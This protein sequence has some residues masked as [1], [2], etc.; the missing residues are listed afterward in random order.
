MLCIQKAMKFI[1]SSLTCNPCNQMQNS[2]DVDNPEIVSN[3]VGHQF[4]TIVWNNDC[5]IV[6]HKCCNGTNCLLE[7]HPLILNWFEKEMNDSQSP[8]FEAAAIKIYSEYKRN[9]IHFR[10]H[11]NYRKTG[12][13]HDWVM[14]MYE[15]DDNSDSEDDDTEN[16]F[17]RNENPSKILCFFM[18]DDSEKSMLWYNLVTLVIINKIPFFFNYGKKEYVRRGNIFQPMLC[19]VPVDS[20]GCSIL[21][22]EDNRSISETSTIKQLQDG[23]TVVI[24]CEEWPKKFLPRIPQHE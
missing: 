3:L 16:L 2:V 17:D 8:F 24:L 9:Q 14:V 23:I 18:V 10:A 7:L 13:W 21:V 5:H 20:F 1:E 12:C 4:A 6:Y 22:I 19:F 15:D 11:P